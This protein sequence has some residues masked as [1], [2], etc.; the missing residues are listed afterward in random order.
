MCSILTHRW[1]VQ[2]C[3]VLPWRKLMLC[4]SFPHVWNG[5]EAM[6][7]DGR[8]D[9]WSG[10]RDLI[11]G[12]P[13]FCKWKNGTF[14]QKSK[15]NMFT[16]SVWKYNFEKL[17]TWTWRTIC[18]WV[19][20]QAQVWPWRCP[21]VKRYQTRDWNG[22][23]HFPLKS[24]HCILWHI[25]SMQLSEF[26]VIFFL[27]CSLTCSLPYKQTKLWEES[28]LI[29][30][31]SGSVWPMATHIFINCCPA[32]FVN[33]LIQLFPLAALHTATAL[34][35]RLWLTSHVPQLNPY[36]HFLRLRLKSFP[37]TDSKLA[38]LCVKG[39][40][41]KDIKHN[42]KLQRR[43][44]REWGEGLRVIQMFSGPSPGLL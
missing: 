9:Q 24:L 20:P 12:Q 4:I 17:A 27:D 5:T 22:Q 1:A 8:H 40:H 42:V 19:S 26:I 41:N 44:M 38:Q 32:R 33:N 10:I 6:W 15:T 29:P 11:S 43:G 2:K 21:A 23:F 16:F 30:T 37:L 14:H 39:G 13:F 31:M 36:Q 3:S 34:A 7:G 25:G 18:E 35:S 28:T